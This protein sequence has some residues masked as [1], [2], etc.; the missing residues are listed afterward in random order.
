M[1]YDNQA[2]YEPYSRNEIL[3]RITLPKKELNQSFK[4][5][6]GLQTLF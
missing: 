3:D 1:I 6:Y 4:L 5:D 2:M